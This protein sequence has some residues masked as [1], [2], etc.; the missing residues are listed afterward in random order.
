MFT[1][2]EVG[3]LLGHWVWTQYKSK[4]PNA[5]PSKQAVVR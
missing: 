4:H 2:N 5:D 3:I 1:G